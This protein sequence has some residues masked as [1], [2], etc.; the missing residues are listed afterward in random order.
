MTGYCQ[1]TNPK[2]IQIVS[3]PLATKGCGPSDMD[4]ETLGEFVKRLRT[5]KG[6]SQ[7]A[8]GRLIHVDG[9]TISNLESGRTRTL[10]LKN[11][12]GLP[13]A[14][15]TTMEELQ[16]IA[17]GKADTVTIELPRPVYDAL[18]AKAADKGMTVEQAIERFATGMAFRYIDR[19][20]PA[21]E[22][23]STSSQVPEGPDTPGKRGS[24]R[25]REPA[26]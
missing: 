1:A 10:K 12:V 17:E 13:A 18:A 19:D 14:L 4:V 8:L 20:P 11:L 5:A 22:P 9:Q 6:L 3:N 24:R 26:R 15:G 21:V 2:N 23:A 25:T 7:A 16:R